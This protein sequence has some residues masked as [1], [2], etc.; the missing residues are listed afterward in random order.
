MQ[1]TFGK[2]T[3][4]LKL[5]KKSFFERNT[6]SYKSKTWIELGKDINL[7]SD[8][9]YFQ[10]FN[11][12]CGLRSYKPER[13]NKLIKDLIEYDSKISD[14]EQKEEIKQKSNVVPLK[15]KM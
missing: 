1:I 10:F 6:I 3:F 7:E 11:L 14:L 4:Y 2:K 12:L 9:Y 5:T 8:F 15:P 13:I